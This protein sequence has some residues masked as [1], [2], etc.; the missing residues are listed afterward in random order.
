MIKYSGLDKSVGELSILPV[1]V[2]E[3][4]NAVF[5]VYSLKPNLLEGNNVNVI[6][7]VWAICIA[8]ASMK[9]LCSQVSLRE[10]MACESIG[11]G[12]WDTGENVMEY[13]SCSLNA[14]SS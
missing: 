4:E 13:L 7:L 11:Y 2:G 10:S 14:I 9:D 3:G 8:D 12:V 1:H 5:V 6:D